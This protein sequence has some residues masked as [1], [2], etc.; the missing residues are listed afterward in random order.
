VYGLNHA[1]GQSVVVPSQIVDMYNAAK[2]VYDQYRTAPS[3]S[4]SIPVLQLWGFTSG[5]YT[6]PSDD[7]IDAAKKL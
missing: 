5:N 1:G 4:R 6:K 3:I 7:D 2:T